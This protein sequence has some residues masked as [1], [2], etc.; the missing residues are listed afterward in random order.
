MWH[1]IKE[2]VC[3]KKKMQELTVA[4]LMR[5]DKELTVCS[6]HRPPAE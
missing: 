4:W 6:P 1:S 3:T 2:V 5:E